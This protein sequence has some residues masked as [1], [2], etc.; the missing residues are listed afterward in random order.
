[1]CIT[2]QHLRAAPGLDEQVPGPG[3]YP[4]V[5]PVKQLIDPLDFLPAG[6]IAFIADPHLQAGIFA[7]PMQVWRAASI[8]KQGDAV[9]RLV[10]HQAKKQISPKG[11][12]P[13]RLKVCAYYNLNI[14]ITSLSLIKSLFDLL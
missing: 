14:G 6:S 10:G 3:K 13:L 1:M 5:Q 11:T 4:V 2:F 12:Y 8:L 7:V 9:V